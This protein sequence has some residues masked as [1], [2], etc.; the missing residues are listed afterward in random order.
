M[1][2]RSF[3]KK[4]KT[5]R[6]L[7]IVIMLI[8]LFAWFQFSQYQTILNT[9]VNAE[10]TDDVSFI[11]RKGETFNTITD[12]LVEKELISD[13]NTFK[14]YARLNG[15]DRKVFPG[16][17]L[18]RQSQTIPEIVETLSN[19]EKSQVVLT[20]LEG[21]TVQDIDDELV[22]LDLIQPGDFTKAVDEFDGYED[23]FFLDREAMQNLIHPLEGYLFPDTYFLDPVEYSNEALISIMLNNFE[24]RVGDELREADRT[25]HDIVIMASILEKEVRTDDDI[26]VVA[27]LLWK[28][29]DN[30]WLLGA[31]AT[32]LYL[33]EDRSI[34]Y[35]DL[36][37]DTPYNTRLN[38]GLP[39]GP[40]GNAGLKSFMGALHPEESPYWFYL[41]TL[42][43]GEVIYAETNQQHEGNKAQY[44]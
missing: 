9:P 31:D 35:Y 42:D 2:K 25:I 27:G 44:L 1:K 8:G 28:R 23:Y 37:E 41:T 10:S 26:P 30:S 39:P 6:Y 12:N 11:I 17:F 24:N 16:R 15:F 29:L 20:V 43:T 14:I 22:K 32:L 18:L 5:G 33:K 4:R 34:D 3:Q 36:Q 21:T 38:P 40:I 19:A 7:L 13:K